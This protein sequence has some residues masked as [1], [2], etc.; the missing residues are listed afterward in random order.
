MVNAANANERARFLRASGISEEVLAEVLAKP[1][2][3]QCSK[4]AQRRGEISE[5]RR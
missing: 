1:C 3:E 2:V 5:V 4:R